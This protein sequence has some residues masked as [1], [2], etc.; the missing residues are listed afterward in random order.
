MRNKLVQDYPADKL[1]VIVISD[2]SDD[3][4]DD[5]VIGINDPRVTLI[6]QIPRRGKT[7]GLNLAMPQ[8][9]GDIIV[10]SDANSLYGPDTTKQLTAVF[11]DPEV[12]YVTGRM[13]LRGT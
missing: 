3:G 5:L 9:T 12:G 6:R 10:F 7:S 4:T 8:A 1:R 2:E 11:E 13:A